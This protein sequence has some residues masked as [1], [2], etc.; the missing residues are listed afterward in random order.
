[1]PCKGAKRG[2]KRRKMSK[3][4]RERVI[5]GSRFKEAL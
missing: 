2:H 3:R 4:K 1:M 5:D